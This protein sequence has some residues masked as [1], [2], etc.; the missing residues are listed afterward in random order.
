MLQSPR[1]VTSMRLTAFFLLSLGCGGCF[2]VDTRDPPA[3]AYR[4]HPPSLGPPS[5]SLTT[6]PRDVR[7]MYASMSAQSDGTSIVVRAALL[8]DA[9]FFRTDQG[10]YFTATIGGDTLVLSEEPHADAVVHYSA[11]FPE[12]KTASSVVVSFVR[13]NG[14]AGAPWSVVELPAPFAITSLPPASVTLG[15]RSY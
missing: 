14:K 9:R 2:Y 7:E 1:D 13:R 12:Q 3:P 6:G 15:E 10:D 8:V 5:A 11:T 4:G